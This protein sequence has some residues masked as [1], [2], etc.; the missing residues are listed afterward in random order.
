MSSNLKFIS[1][2]RVTITALPLYYSGYL[3]KRCR[4]EV[5]TEREREKLQVALNVNDLTCSLQD[6]KG[7]HAE[8]RGATIFLYQDELQETVKKCDSFKMT[9][10]KAFA[11]LCVCVCVSAHR[12]VGPGEAEIYSV[13]VFLFEEDAR[14]F[15]PQNEKRE[16][17]AEGGTLILCHDSAHKM[18]IKK[19]N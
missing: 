12:E 3:L 15:Y 4:A 14:D 19:T 8:L 18:Y 1:Q 13:R 17:A 11:D 10:F 9:S 16:S 5:S 2:R 7:Y 6:F